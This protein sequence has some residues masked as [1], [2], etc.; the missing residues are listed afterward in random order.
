MMKQFG[1]VTPGLLV[2]AL[3]GFSDCRSRSDFVNPISTLR[4]V[5]NPDDGGKAIPQ[6]LSTATKSIDIVIY[7]IGDPD[8]QAALLAAMQRGVEVRVIMDN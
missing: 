6:I 7:Q 4:V 1:I 5:V 2:G 8:I 3:I